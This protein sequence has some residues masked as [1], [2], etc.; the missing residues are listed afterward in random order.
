[1]SVHL[2]IKIATLHQIQQILPQTSQQMST[3]THICECGRKHKK[4]DRDSKTQ[5]KDIVNI[6]PNSSPR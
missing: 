1:M 5:K 3:D 4:D 2:F 6:C